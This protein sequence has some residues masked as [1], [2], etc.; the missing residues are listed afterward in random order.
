MENGRIDRDLEHEYV[1]SALDFLANILY[2]GGKLDLNLRKL[3]HIPRLYK[4]RDM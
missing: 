3:F 2:R 1:Q 4:E